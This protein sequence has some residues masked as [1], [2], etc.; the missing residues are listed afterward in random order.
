M[1]RAERASVL[2]YTYI[3]RLVWLCNSVCTVQLNSRMILGI[4]EGKKLCC[5]MKG[6]TEHVPWQIEE[7][8]E[9]G[10]VAEG[11]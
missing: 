9:E 7:N 1:S 2:R 5:C 3:F 6:L 4:G 10:T 8:D 11:M